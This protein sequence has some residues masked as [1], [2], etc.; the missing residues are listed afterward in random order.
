MEHSGGF[1]LTGGGSVFGIGSG[2][3][4]TGGGDGESASYISGESSKT[5][6]MKQV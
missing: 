3:G 2:G 4:D 6:K 5:G 1:T